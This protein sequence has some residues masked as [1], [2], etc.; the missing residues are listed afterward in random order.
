M[1]T[2]ILD[3]STTDL[4]ALKEHLEIPESD[5]THDTY[6]T[7][8]LRRVKSKADAYCSNPFLDEDTE[9]ELE[10][11]DYVEQ[12]VLEV[13]AKKFRVREN[14]LRSESLSGDGSFTL[15]DL[16]YEDLFPGWKPFA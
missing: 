13:C 1:V 6:L 8:L 5:T 10:I 3:R 9:E 4:A 11:P 16:D 14:S 7:K 12:W 15:G 2:A